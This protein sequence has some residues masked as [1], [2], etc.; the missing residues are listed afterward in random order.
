VLPASV[1][2]LCLAAGSSCRGHQPATQVRPQACVDMKVSSCV[3]NCPHLRCIWA[4]PRLC[5]HNP[6]CAGAPGAPLPQNATT[7]GACRKDIESFLS[8]DSTVRL[9]VFSDNGRDYTA[10]VQPPLKF[11]KKAVFFVKTH[12][13]VL[14]AENIGE[15]LSFGETGDAP[16]ETL[17]ALTSNVFLPLLTS[18]SNQTGWPDVLKRDVTD[19]IH[20]FAQSIFVT[21]GQTKGQT[22]LPLPA[23]VR[24]AWRKASTPAAAS[25]Q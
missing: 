14:T 6:L 21:V 9:I 18:N 15:I 13:A 24:E 20:K 4:R 25:A 3:C 12:P 2:D 10:S 11:K 5:A 17:S 1:F 8:K 22:Q 7:L 19:S 23:G 16:L